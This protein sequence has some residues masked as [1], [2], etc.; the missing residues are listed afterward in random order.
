M[1]TA[2]GTLGHDV[3]AVPEQAMGSLVRTIDAQVEWL[4]G[5]EVAELRA[6]T[7]SGQESICPAWPVVPRYELEV[8]K[9][10]MR[11]LKYERSELRHSVRLWTKQRRAAH[12]VPDHATSLG[13]CNERTARAKASRRLT[14]KEHA[15]GAAKAVSEEATRRA[16][17]RSNKR[18]RK[19]ASKQTGGPGANNR[20]NRVR[21]SAPGQPQMRHNGKSICFA[22]Q[23]P[24]GCTREKCSHQHIC[25]HCYGPHS[26]DQCTNFVKS[27]AAYFKKRG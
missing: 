26:F 15:T 18:Q 25:A 2:R 1:P 23:G 5:D 19:Q 24:D 6:M 11:Q 20:Y 3:P 8:R 21:K 4:L 16:A 14:A 22:F 13:R 9:E 17:A 12:Q 27:R 10:A 7:P